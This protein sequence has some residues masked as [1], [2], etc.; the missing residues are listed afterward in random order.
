MCTRCMRLQSLA[1]RSL[2]RGVYHGWFKYKGMIV[3][4]T[5]TN[6]NDNI[7][8]KH[9][10]AMEGDEKASVATGEVG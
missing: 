7:N 4:D 6:S 8:N 5:A 3:I 2:R 10:C 1:V 9:D